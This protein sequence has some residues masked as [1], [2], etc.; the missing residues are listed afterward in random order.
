MGHIEFDP[1][2]FRGREGYFFM[3]SLVVDG[4]M[5]YWLLTADTAKVEPFMKKLAAW[6]ETKAITSDKKVLFALETVGSDCWVKRVRIL[7]S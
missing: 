5:D 7:R 1:S 2:E 6:Y 3:T 4:L